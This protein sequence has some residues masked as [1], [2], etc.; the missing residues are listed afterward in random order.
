MKLNFNTTISLTRSIFYSRYQKRTKNNFRTLTCLLLSSAG[1]YRG[2]YGFSGRSI[3]P[4]SFGGKGKSDCAKQW[5]KY[6]RG[7]GKNVI[8]FRWGSSIGIGRKSEN[9]TLETGGA[10][11]R[12]MWRR[13]VVNGF[14]FANE[15]SLAE[16]EV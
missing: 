3:V 16:S 14:R 12:N 1:I 15:L 6:R 5:R 9:T 8:C 13:F 7:Q 4:A 2:C 11:E 10:M